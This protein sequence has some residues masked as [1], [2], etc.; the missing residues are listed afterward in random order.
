MYTELCD[1]GAAK[2]GKCHV[3][4][5]NS[6]NSQKNL[7]WLQHVKRYSHLKIAHRSTSVQCLVFK[8]LEYWKDICV[9]LRSW[10]PAFNVNIFNRLTRQMIHIYLNS[11][12]ITPNKTIMRRSSLSENF[13]VPNRTGKLSSTRDLRRHVY[14]YRDCFMLCA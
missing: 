7:V 4:S 9:E 11:N 10:L 2:P 13:K 14:V 12:R 8:I 3:R 6:W 1:L 5:E